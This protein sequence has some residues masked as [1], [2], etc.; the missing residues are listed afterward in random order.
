KNLIN[1][2]PLS[3]EAAGFQV[4]PTALPVHPIDFAGEGALSG[5]G[6]GRQL[7]GL[8]DGGFIGLEEWLVAPAPQQGYSKQQGEQK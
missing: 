3:G 6:D 1:R 5:G 2:V 4:T 8:C 7:I